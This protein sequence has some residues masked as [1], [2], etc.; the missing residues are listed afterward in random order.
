MAD[1]TDSETNTNKKAQQ[2]HDEIS[3]FCW[4]LELLCRI[5]RQSGNVG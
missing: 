2:L 1:V 3:G 4:H 5:D